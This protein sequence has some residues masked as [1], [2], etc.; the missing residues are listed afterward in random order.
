MVRYSQ[1]KEAA[2]TQRWAWGPQILEL[3]NYSQENKQHF[4]INLD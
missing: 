3:M 1:S 2:R 4:Q